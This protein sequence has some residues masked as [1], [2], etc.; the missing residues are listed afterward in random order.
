LTVLELIA[1]SH[2]Q[3]GLYQYDGIDESI[4]CE[5]IETGVT[6]LFCDG[7]YRVP[8]EINARLGEIYM[9]GVGICVTTYILIARIKSIV[10]RW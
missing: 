9:H 6:R 10:R 4:D 7:L 2:R 1:S 5:G 8:A 3:S